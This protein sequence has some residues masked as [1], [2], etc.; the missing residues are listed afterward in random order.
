[1][2]ECQNCGAHVTEAYAR[3]FIPRYGACTGAI[4]WYKDPVGG[5]RG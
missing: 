3:V 5:G 4:S 1:M 2:S